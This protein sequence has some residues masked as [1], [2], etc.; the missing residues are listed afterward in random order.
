MSDSFV[1]IP[2]S[3][4]CDAVHSGDA[5]LAIVLYARPTFT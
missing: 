2:M 4:R 3:F 1:T 5:G